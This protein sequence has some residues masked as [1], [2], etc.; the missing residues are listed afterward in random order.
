MKLSSSYIKF[1]SSSESEF[2]IR[3]ADKMDKMDRTWKYLRY[4]FSRM[5]VRKVRDL[6]ERVNENVRIVLRICC[7]LV[8]YLVIAS[9]AYFTTRDQGD[10]Y[11]HAEPSFYYEIVWAYIVF[12]VLFM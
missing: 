6:P 3:L 8:Y 4:L 12:L 10:Y 1:I 7:N 9:V 11:A 2:S 5:F